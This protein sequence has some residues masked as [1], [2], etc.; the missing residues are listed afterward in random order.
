MNNL[1]KSIVFI[2]LLLTLCDSY[3]SLASLQDLAADKT[4]ETLLSQTS[5]EELS[6]I[7]PSMPAEMQQRLKGKVI[8]RC[9]DAL[10]KALT[11]QPKELKGHTDWIASVVFSPCGR[12]ALTGSDDNTARL[13]DLTT[14]ST[15]KELK[16]HTECVFSVALSPCGKYALTGSRDNTVRLWDVST[17][18]TLQKLKGH[19]NWVTSV[20]FSPCGKYVLTGSFDNTA[21]LWDLATGATIKQ[22]KGHTSWISSV[23]FSPCGNYALTGSYDSTAR[24]W[25]L[26]TSTT[27]RELKGHTDIVK[28]VIFSPCG[29]FALTGSHDYTARLWD[30]V[31]G[32]TIKEL[33]G[34]TECVFSVALSPCSK[35]A[36]T[37]ST[38]KT[39]RL[40]DLATGTAI[41]ELK[42][43][44]D[45]IISVAFSPDGKYALTGS[46]DR[47]A[48]LWP[49]AQL[50]TLSLEQALFVLISQEWNINVEDKYTQNLL[51]S[52]SSTVD[53]YGTLPS[54]DYATNPLVK[55]YIN[56]RRRQLFDAAVTDDIDAV[57]A[58]IKKGFNTVYT[59]DKAGNN[60]WHYAFRGHKE[61]DVLC[62]NEKVL[63]YLLEVE[64][65]NKGLVKPNKAGIYPF[66]VGLF[67]NKEFTAKFIKDL[68]V[69]VA[70]KSYCMV[71]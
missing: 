53:P 25:D 4:I 57:K 18:T 39:A 71:Q 7:I 47:T 69:V 61:N 12:Y 36:L 54:K 59:I 23:V 24:L 3:S 15:I 5:Q 45:C 56:L 68:S 13:W 42:G 63:A 33:K 62:P 19:T 41:K 8:E 14:G 51:S 35:Y 67:N 29:K 44:T 52:L 64:D 46:W 20:A 32:S 22:L 2:P 34:H 50:S 28:L 31:T 65:K 17:G 37:G 9:K 10:H 49:I 55:A 48:R 26:T 40:W 38:D 60:L 27:I 66:A 43:H 6:A 58:L 70:K 11:I 1:H 16:G 21:R 30:A